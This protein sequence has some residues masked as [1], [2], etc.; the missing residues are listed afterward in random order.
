MTGDEVYDAAVPRPRASGED[1]DEEVPRSYY[2]GAWS[3][4]SRHFFYTVHDE[5]YRPYQVRRHTLGTPV[6]DDVLVL[7]EPDE[8]YELCVRAPRSGGP[9]VLWAESRDT[10]EV[11]VLDGDDP[12][13]P[14]RS[15]GGRRRGVE[16]H[17]EH[18]RLPD[19]SEHAARR[20]QRRGHRVPAGGCA[21]ARATPT[22]TTRR[23][24]RSGPRT[25]PSGSSGSSVRLPRGAAASG[26]D[27]QRL[28]RL[29]P[30]D[31][32]DGDGR[33]PR[34]GLPDRAPWRWAAT[35]STTPTS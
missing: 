2:G 35:R 31:D 20:H 29:L 23:G 30:V 13:A 26:R 18:L 34:A 21:G 14:P 24:G 7:E 28:L 15:V 4:D 3:A 19:G 10:R 16:Y 17:A 5:A 11:W 22:R 25:P 33:R 12:A 32:L 6:A 9:V 8:R 27:G 1:L